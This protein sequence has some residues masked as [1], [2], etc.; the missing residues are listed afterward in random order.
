MKLS[1]KILLGFFGF[2][3]VY[4]TAAFAEVRFSGTPNWIDSDN[5]KAETVDLKGVTFINV[6]NVDRQITV[7]GSDRSAL[8]VRS[9]SGDKLK[10]LTYKI[11]GDTL[12]LSDFESEDVKNVSITVFVRKATLKGINV[13]SSVVIVEELEQSHLL[14]SEDSGRIWMSGCILSKIDVDLSNASLLNIAETVLDTMSTKVDQSE[15]MVSS[16]VGI[17]QGTVD[18]NSLLK[19]GEI[20]EIQVKKDK[21]SRLNLYQ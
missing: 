4:L 6:N 21:Q 1:N 15:L 17:V 3:F 11:S 14:I 20:G 19:L 10:N 7:R 5:S 9:F 12:T 16:P 2:V 8:E 13:Q 18:N